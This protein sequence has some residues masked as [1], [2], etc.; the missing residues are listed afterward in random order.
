M[1]RITQY[2]WALAALASL[3]RAVLAQEWKQVRPSN[4]GIPGEQ[5]HYGA[6]AP[7]GK[8]WVAGR[9]PFWGEGGYGIYDPVNDTWATLSNVDTP[10]PSQ[11]ARGVVF[12][13]DNVV[14]MAT[15]DGL[16][17]KQSETWT[18]YTTA[19]SPLLHNKVRSVALAPNGDLWVNNSGVNTSN[20]AVFRFQPQS[21]VW[22][23]YRVGEQIPFAA[24]WYQLGALLVTPDGHVWVGNDTLNGIAEF[25]GSTWTLRG[26]N[27]G[28]FGSGLVDQSG[29]LWLL[30]GIGGGNQFWRYHVQTAQWE[31]FSPANT[32]LVNT[33]I[34]KLSIDPQGRIYCGNWYGQVIR[35]QDGVWTLVASVGD[36]VYGIG[37]EADG[38]M[39]ITTLGNGRTGE[40]HRLDAAGNPIRRYNTWNTGMPWYFID[41]MSLDPQGNLWF[42]SGEAGLSRLAPGT[43]SAPAS[44]QRWRNWG[45]H[46]SG[47]EPYPFAG[48]EPMGAYYQDRGGQGWM[49]GNGIAR[50]DPVSG[51]FTG[52]WNWQNN[53]GMGVTNISSFAE[54]SFGN[55]FAADDYGATFRFDGALWV[56]QPTGAGSYTSGYDG[57]KSDPSGRVWSMGWLRAWLW[58]GASWAEVGQSWD[59]FGKGGVN[60]YEF[61]GAGT[62]WVGTNEGLLRV[63]NPPNGPTTFFTPAN[64]PLPAAQVQG[65]DVRASDGAM[66]V[67]AHLFQSTTPFPS[68]VSVI[69]GDPAVP[70]NWRIYRYGQDPIRHYQLGAVQFDRDGNLWISAISEGC[71]VLMNSAPPCYANCDGSTTTPAL[72]VQ[73]FTCFLQRYAAGDTYAN[74]DQSTT[75]PVLNVQDFTCFLQRYA[76]GCP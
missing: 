53:P 70:A 6:L 40:L 8:V 41:R 13:P 1:N 31:Q 59:I 68:G 72:N 5:L 50:W 75:A 62:L 35:Y 42:A 2:L 33:T 32:P 65:I 25:D 24:P 18:V 49:G 54:D 4:T 60:V 26:E 46:N 38:D 44:Q 64:S 14:W 17:R 28:R 76:A 7:D 66:A 16:V 23:R 10:Q 48:N 3:G 58:D 37:I 43:A 61:D 11:W 21:G 20:A 56:Q 47:S 69:S 51:Q 9:W 29:D 52:F 45:N 19:N 39:W 30:A 73:D 34:T 12:A 57:V 67:S 15:D 55:L 63:E 22:T 27:V 74:C 71:S 36:A